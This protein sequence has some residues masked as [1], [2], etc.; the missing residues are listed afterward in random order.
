M[1]NQEEIIHSY[2]DSDQDYAE[3]MKAPLHVHPVFELAVEKQIEFRERR[4]A[5]TEEEIRSLVDEMRSVTDELDAIV[6]SSGMQGMPVRLT[7]SGIQLP[8]ARTFIESGVLTIR[9]IENGPVF[10]ELELT[11]EAGGA[12]FGFGTRMELISEN[13]IDG[14]IRPILVYQVRVGAFLMVH[15]SGNIFATGDVGETQV[16][17]IDDFTARRIESTLTILMENEDEA[18]IKRVNNI[19]IALAKKE[20]PDAALLRYIG[21]Q[22]AGLINRLDDDMD[23]KYVDALIDLIACYVDWDKKYKIGVSSI[24]KIP[25]LNERINSEVELI[26]GTP[27]VNFEVAVKQLVVMPSYINNN[28][29]LNESGRKSLYAATYTEDASWYLKLS[30]LE[31]FESD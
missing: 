27:L 30:D 9:P 8:M 1:D 25:R 28:G 19:N 21:Y 6:V 22:A 12:F 24:L 5:L 17:F 2:Y 13:D 10:D 20:K 3:Q 7:G 29:V 23:Q 31:I 15:A 26:E 16:E 18:V 14:G 11:Q 4:A